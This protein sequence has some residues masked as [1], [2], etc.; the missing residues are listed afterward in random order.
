MSDLNPSQTA[1]YGDNLKYDFKEMY[2]EEKIIHIV[3][4]AEALDKDEIDYPEA[5]EKLLNVL[6]DE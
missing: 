3:R 2:P 1:S 4:I 5:K 6:N